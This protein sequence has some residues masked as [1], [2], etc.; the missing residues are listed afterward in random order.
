MPPLANGRP[1]P[2]ASL[3]REAC[4]SKQPCR[5][6]DWK[7]TA[8]TVPHTYQATA[9]RFVPVAVFVMVLII[10]L[11]NAGNP[12]FRDPDLLWHIAVGRRILE[13]R[14]FPWVDE[15]SHTFQGHAWIAKEWLSQ[16]LFA[17]IYDAVG[18]KGLA[19]LIGCAIALTFTLLFMVL[20]QQMRVVPALIGS[21]FAYSLATPHFLVRPHMLA[22]PLVVLWIAGLVRAAETR[23]A[24]SPILLALMI[25]WANLH[26]GFTLGLAFIVPFAIEAVL[27]AG[28]A[29]RVATAKRWAAFLG[30]AVLA[31]LVTPY[32]YL[33]LWATYQVFGGNEALK[34]INEWQPLNF[35]N[36]WYA[37]SLILVALFAGLLCGVKLPFIRCVLVVGMIY[38]GLVHVRFV[39]LAAIMIPIL[40]AGPLSRQFGYISKAEPDPILAVLMNIVGRPSLRLLAVFLAVVGISA[41]ALVPERN[42]PPEM[43]PAAA[44][45]YLGARAKE[46]KIYNDYLFGGYLIFRGIPT[47]IDG[48]SDQL[49]GGGF[50]G[51]LYRTLDGPT[52]GFRELLD[53]H[54][55][56]F[57]LVRPKT[58]DAYALDEGEGWRRLY[59]DDTAILYERVR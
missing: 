58:R 30:A 14:S 31:A 43:A 48:R 5:M 38:Q 12:L 46:G 28:P 21:L 54:D 17:F 52:H 44:V 4:R 40:I 27:A 37:G 56:R 13:T 2:R 49:F 7:M 29:D 11:A 25:L 9:S 55:I 51:Q 3:S 41:S 18:W 16:I 23:T 32:G 6:I 35:A 33:A 8:T 34:W 24:P 42:L 19:V 39:A 59:A 20:E 53:K 1:W 45:D 10:F 15:F 50:L 57:A 36:D 47:F 22:F 26:G